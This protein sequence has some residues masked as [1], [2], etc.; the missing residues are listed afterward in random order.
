MALEMASMLFGIGFAYGYLCCFVV[1]LLTFLWLQIEFCVDVPVG[2]EGG[3]EFY[4]SENH[5][6]EH[7]CGWTHCL[8]E[9]NVDNSDV[10]S[11]V[12][13][14]TGKL[15]KQVTGELEMTL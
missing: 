9:G 6:W 1:G 15:V 11:P 14:T 8:S 2:A 5:R 7:C 13:A 12:H 3:L 4:D 10:Q